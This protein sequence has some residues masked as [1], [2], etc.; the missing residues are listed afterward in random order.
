M[1]DREQQLFPFCIVWTVI[2]C[3]SWLLPW[4]GHAGICEYFF[5]TQLQRRS[6]RFRRLPHQRI[7]RPNQKRKLSFG[8]PLKYMQLSEIAREKYDSSMLEVNEV[9]SRQGHNLCW[10]CSIN[11]AT[12]A[13]TT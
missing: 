8:R 9:F 3:I 12:T 11:E 5:L 1:I 7:A 2:P 13:T 10:Y 6:Q 4:I